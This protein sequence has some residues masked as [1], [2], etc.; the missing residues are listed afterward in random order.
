MAFFGEES[1]RVSFVFFDEFLALIS[2]L[3]VSNDKAVSRDFAGL[4]KVPSSS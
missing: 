2:S 4:H 1:I 3:A